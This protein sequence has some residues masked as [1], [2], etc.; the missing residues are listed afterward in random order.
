MSLAEINDQ[1]IAKTESPVVATARSLFEHRLT[2]I[3][4]SCWEP[5]TVTEQQNM[6]KRDAKGRYADDEI[7]ALWQ[8]FQLGH[9]LDDGAVASLAKQAELVS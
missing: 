5:L 3:A 8:G 6:L 4:E 9:A 7:N 2:V 1:S